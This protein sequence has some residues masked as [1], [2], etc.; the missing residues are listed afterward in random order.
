MDL[1][2]LK[3]AIA[4]VSDPEDKEISELMMILLAAL[5]VGHP[6]KDWQPRPGTDKST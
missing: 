2:Q 1:T 6:R 4:G 5:E 3:S